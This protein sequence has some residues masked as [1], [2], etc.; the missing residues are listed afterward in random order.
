MR[1]EM[2]KPKTIT[3]TVV[4]MNFRGWNKESK[5]FLKEQCP[6]PVAIEREPDN[7]VD[8]NAIQVIIPG[9]FAWASGMG[10][11]VKKRWK[12]YA[13]VPLGYIRA[14]IAEN[15]APLMDDGLLDIG[16]AVITEVDIAAGEAEM[17]CEV[18]GEAVA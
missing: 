6:F 1:K 4:G 12:L 16:N 13:N 7:E 11:S 10:P 18:S 9:N 3:L 5:R 15:Y 8:P 2:I 17:R 14:A